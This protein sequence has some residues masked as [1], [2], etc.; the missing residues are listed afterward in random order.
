MD[1]LYFDYYQYIAIKILGVIYIV[2]GIF[3]V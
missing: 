1:I 3:E 2:L